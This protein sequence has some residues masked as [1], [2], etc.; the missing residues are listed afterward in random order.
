MKIKG[1]FIALVLCALTVLGIFLS[2]DRDEAVES[3]GE[4]GSGPVD[5]IDFSFEKTELP[6][7]APAGFVVLWESG[8]GML[9]TGTEIRLTGMTGHFTDR[10]E[11]NGSIKTI[12]SDFDVEPEA[13]A[14]LYEFL[15]SHSADK[16]DQT[17]GD[18]FDGTDD[19]YTLSWDSKSIHV[20]GLAVEES[21]EKRY[22]EIYVYL[23]EFFSV[24]AL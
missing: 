13:Y 12:E 2:L 6:E 22:D 24:H 5:L 21:D 14:E 23:S 1:W 16:I 10:I 15:R 4:G 20:W 19:G 11:M 8:G 17:E 18:I 7:Q 3:G 9:Q